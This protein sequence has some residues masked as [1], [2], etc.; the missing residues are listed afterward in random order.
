LDKSHLLERRGVVLF[1]FSGLLAEILRLLF[2][3][4]DESRKGLQVLVLRRRDGAGG[5]LG[6][7]VRALRGQPL[8]F[9]VGVLAGF[10][11]QSNSAF[12]A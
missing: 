8:D 10:L 4:L 7:E 6:L 5:L 9:V 11:R 12:S 3:L 1:Q 2:C